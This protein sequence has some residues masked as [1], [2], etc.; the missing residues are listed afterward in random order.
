MLASVEITTRQ[1]CPKLN[2]RPRRAGALPTNVSRLRSHDGALLLSWRANPPRRM[3]ALMIGGRVRGGPTASSSQRQCP[4]RSCSLSRG[5]GV[6]G[7]IRPAAGLC[8]TTLLCC[9]WSRLP[10]MCVP[11]CMRQLGCRSLSVQEAGKGSG[12]KCR[13]CQ[14]G[15]RSHKSSNCT[16][17]PVPG[18]HRCPRRRTILF[19]P[20]PSEETIGAKQRS[21][22]GAT[23]TCQPP[24]CQHLHKP[25]P[26][27]P[28]LASPGQPAQSWGSLR[29]LMLQHAEAHC[30]C[31]PHI[32]LRGLPCQPPQRGLCPTAMGGCQTSA[33]AAALA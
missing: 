22:S 27:T 15:H 8:R 1:A 5:Q 13:S 24:R 3:Q 20:S 25:L 30:K 28:M 29:L 7:N 23:A 19:G 32:L 12:G 31:L 17:R 33:L 10:T 21:R 11:R 4:R 18:R 14:L 2:L 26:P 9:R 6:A 16:R